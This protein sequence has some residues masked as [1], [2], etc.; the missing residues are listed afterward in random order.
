MS[1]SASTIAKLDDFGV[2]SEI[3]SGGSR[4]LTV[5]S[6]FNLKKFLLRLNFEILKLKYLLIY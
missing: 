3:I 5:K 4:K 1:S 2:F 6:S